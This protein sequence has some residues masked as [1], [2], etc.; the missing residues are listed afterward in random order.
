[1]D[2]AKIA[3]TDQAV[4]H[5]RS[6]IEQLA[7]AVWDTPELSLHEVT[8]SQTI[9]HMV[10]GHGFTITSTG[11]A[12]VPTAFVA[13]WGTGGPRIG[14]LAEYD[15]LPGL[16]NAAVP[17]Q[18][19]RADGKTVGHGCGHNLL[20]AGIVGAAIALKEVLDSRGL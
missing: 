5:A 6:A 16:G 20:G 3:S 11:T 7:L 1:M 14:F 9:Q 8:S 10:Q 18:E 19:P 2:T 13:E 4:E 12:G 15:A 17:R